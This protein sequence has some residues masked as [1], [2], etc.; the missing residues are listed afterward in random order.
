MA[1]SLV[2]RT[3]GFVVAACVLVPGLALATVAV[4]PPAGAAGTYTIVDWGALVSG[5]TS[6]A[7]LGSG[8]NSTGDGA[9]L[10]STNPGDPLSGTATHGVLFKGGVLRDLGALSPTDGSLANGVNAADD[11]VGADFDGTHFHAVKWAGGG[12]ITE[13]AGG[14]FGEAVAVNDSG[15]IVGGLVDAGNT[16]RQAVQFNGDGSVTDLGTIPD[17]ADQGQAAA[18]GISAA[19]VIVGAVTDSFNHTVAV[20]F[21]GGAAHKLPALPGWLNSVANGVSPAGGYIVGGASS[22]TTGVAAEFGPGPAAV[23]L[24]MLPGDASS[25]AR[26][27][28]T[29][30]IVVGSSSDTTGH[31][32][33]AMFS[34]GQVIDLTSLLPANSGWQLEDAWAVNDSGQISGTGLHNGVTRAFTM[35]P[36]VLV[37]PPFGP[38]IPILLNIPVIGPVLAAIIRAI[39]VVLGI[40]L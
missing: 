11:V 28:N 25:I 37:P 30:G 15:T 32:H 12:S 2:R 26:S 8:L 9:G 21:S 1:A 27:V 34:N 18:L 29:S 31:D 4:A 24:G 10:A 13:L 7:N 23:S 16:P 3:L 20:T 6:F 14:R 22:S 38:L 5:G 40:G 35:S 33:A 19:G 17:S 36:M 39:A